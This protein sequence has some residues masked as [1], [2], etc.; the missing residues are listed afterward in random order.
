AVNLT[1]DPL[2]SN[3]TNFDLKGFKVVD[4]VLTGYGTLAGLVNGEG[5]TFPFELPVNSLG[6]DCQVLSLDLGP[7][8]INA[9]GLVLSVTNIGFDIG[10]LPETSSAVA[11]LVCTAAR[12]ANSG[13]NPYALA[14]ALNRVL[15][16]IQ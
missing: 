3:L 15:P 16:A 5:V 9:S 13:A 4:G 11:S 10:I 8:S 2:P 1:F 12:L 14:A 7:L 6:G